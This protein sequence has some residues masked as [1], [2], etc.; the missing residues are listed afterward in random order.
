MAAFSEHIKTAKQ[1]NIIQHKGRNHYYQLVA[2]VAIKCSD[3]S[4]KPG[5][6]YQ[7]VELIGIVWSLKASNTRMFA[8]AFD[9]FKDEN[10]NFICF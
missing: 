2:V 1:G 3:G 9:D 6:I 8:R 7:E 5:W 4:W 10:W